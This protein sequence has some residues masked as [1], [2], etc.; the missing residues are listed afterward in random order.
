MQGI[1][2][3]AGSR[4]PSFLLGMRAPGKDAQ[5]PVGFPSWQA[6][7][8]IGPSVFVLAIAAVHG[9]VNDAGSS[10]VNWYRSVS[11]STPA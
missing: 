8:K 10:T 7:S 3:L 1:P 4:P 2:I 11:S 9:L 6:N 5:H